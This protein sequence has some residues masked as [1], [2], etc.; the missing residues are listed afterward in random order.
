MICL[1]PTATGQLIDNDVYES[2]SKQ[3]NVYVVHSNGETNSQRNQSQKR[4]DGE[5]TSRNKCISIYNQL[6]FFDASDFVVMQ[7]RDVLHLY[8]D[9]IKRA[10]SHLESDYDIGAVALPYAKDHSKDDHIRMLCV[11]FR[12]EVFQQLEFKASVKKCTCRY[13]AETIESLGY[14]FEYLPSDIPLIKEIL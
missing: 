9:T 11:V 2:I 13:L 14:T 6:K 3:C 7:D 5:K 8:Q 1:I 10:I 12:S 4:I